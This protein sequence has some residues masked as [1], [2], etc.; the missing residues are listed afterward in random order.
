MKIRMTA[1]L[2]TV[3]LMASL[4]IPAFAEENTTENTTEM[5]DSA[6]GTH[7]NDATDNSGADRAV[8]YPH[9]RAYPALRANHAAYYACAPA[10]HTGGTGISDSHGFGN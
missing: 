2:L 4:T 9:I 5:T 6:D 10:V 1:A 7:G 8:Y 3:A